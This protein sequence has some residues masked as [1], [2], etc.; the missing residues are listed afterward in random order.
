MLRFEPCS[1]GVLTNQSL[2]LGTGEAQAR[3]LIHC[4]QRANSCTYIPAQ[5]FERKTGGER[6]SASLSKELI[7]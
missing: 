7:T 2:A 6:Q 5:Q 4:R 1:V 3:Q